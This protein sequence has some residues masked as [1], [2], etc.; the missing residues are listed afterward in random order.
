LNSARAG[1]KQM[2]GKQILA[3]PPVPSNILPV[4]SM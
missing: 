4:W 2:A 3:L 1:Q